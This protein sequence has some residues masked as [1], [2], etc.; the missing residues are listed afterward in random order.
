MAKKSLLPSFDVIFIGVFFA[1]FLMWMVPRCMD[2]KSKLQEETDGVRAQIDS[3]DK[4]MDS[5]LIKPKVVNVTDTAK[6]VLPATT[7]T[8]SG[9]TPSTTAPTTSLST[10]AKLKNLSPKDL[11]GKL[12]ITINNLKLRKSPHLD[13]IVIATLPLYEEVFFLDEVTEFTQQISLGYEIADEPW[14]R[15]RTKKGKDGW[16]YGAGVHYYKK[17]RDGVME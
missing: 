1:F 9:A 14:V 17:K 7:T 11:P 6:A 2:T 16:V 4:V 12:Y 5:L 15:V 13:S 10:Q 8:A 3:L